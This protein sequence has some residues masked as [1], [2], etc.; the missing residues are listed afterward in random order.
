MPTKEISTKEPHSKE[1][2]KPEVQAPAPQPTTRRR[3][4]KGVSPARPKKKVRLG[5]NLGIASGP[6]PGSF[7]NFIYHGGRVIHNPQVYCVFLGDWSSASNQNR[8]TRLAQFIND[9]LNSDYM[10]MLTQYGVG[11]SGQVVN[12]VFIANS[13]QNLAQADIENILQTAINNNT[14]PDPGSNTSSNVYV[15]VLD[16][17]TAVNGSFGGEPVVMC[18]AT[19]DNAFG[20]HFHMNTTAAN[21]LFYAVVPGLTDTC[22]QNSCSNDGLCSL[23]LGQARE[24]RQ[25]QVISHEVS[26]MI[27]N[28]DV[29]G[30]EGWS[31]DAFGDPHENG[32]ICNGQSGTLT[33]GPDTWNV[34]LMYSK[35]DD[36]QTNGATTCVL[37]SSFPL[38]SLLPAC[39]ILLDR[40][41]FGKDEVDAFLNAPVNPG[42]AVFDAAF[43]V[44]VDGFTA[45]QLGITAASFVG[46]PNVQPTFGTTPSV[47]GM[48]ITATSLSAPDQSVFDIIQRFT[49]VCQVTFNND[50]AFP[51]TPGGV[52]TV[53]LS[54]SISG[55]SGQADIQLVNE[56]NPY[57][58]DG[59]I[60][61]LSTD[62]RVFQIPQGNS[63]FGETMGSDASAFITNIITRL[64]TGNTAGQS[65]DDI[66]TDETASAL[67]LSQTVNGTPIYN[68][69]LARVRY[70]ALVADA[71]DV[72]VFF[73][74][75]PGAT[76]ST[77]YDTS[78]TYRRGG[79][80]G[81]IIPLLGFVGGQ[82]TTIPCFASSRI[83]TTSLSMNAQ[84]DEPNHQQINHD[85]S[86]AEVDVYFGCWLDINQPTPAL[87]PTSAPISP[88]PLDGPYS[89]PL[90]SVQN[91][92][93]N[94]HQCLTAEISMDGVTL[95]TAGQ[96]PGSSDKLAQRNL[97][98]VASDNP[99]SPASHR[100]PMTFEV[101]PTR[102]ETKV[103]SKPDELLINWGDTP[104]GSVASLY[105]PGTSAQHIVQL[106][107]SLY[108][109]HN[110]K[111][112]DAH[113]IQ[114][115]TGGITY[116]P[117]P[118]S[119]GADYAGLLTVDL[120][121]TVKK[122]QVFKVVAQQ[123][124][125][126]A[127]FAV[128]PPPPNQPGAP[129]NAAVNRPVIHWRKVTGSFQL[130]IPVKTKEVMLRPEERLLGVLKWIQKSVP[131]GDRWKPVF[132][133]YVGVIADRVEALGG[134]PAKIKPSPG[135][136]EHGHP[137]HEGGHG[138][139]SGVCTV[140]KVRE[141]I[142]DRYGEFEGFVLETEEADRL[143]YAHE[144]AL[145][146]LLNRSWEERIL[147][148]VVTEEDEPH[149]PAS[150]GLLRK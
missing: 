126:A 26:E 65:F 2:R 106:A 140:G 66:S 127:G 4:I 14:I 89:G 100:V 149:R 88:A 7:P 32:D 138:R 101:K 95:I 123:L 36:Q 47:S 94:I 57:E 28:P 56:P 29:G 108:V 121:K 132:D 72:R 38:P 91:L 93:R 70:R 118:P 10:N 90:Q 20:F 119:V 86:G 1:V 41:T 33:V 3:A 49:W 145:A 115:P 117:I 48:S 128:Q 27:T 64:N 104:E 103:G 150:I 5:G 144:P 122:G 113:T 110:L 6:G 69:G 75:F 102:I 147:I 148:K 131:E 76:T 114:T 74:L 141:L 42:P 46:T 30:S 37:G 68:F 73:R 136:Q 34:Q 9:M 21:E 135:D 146:H 61:W 59:P 35:Y 82:T 87:F 52:D 58:I 25:T 63:I 16:D 107:N 105:L 19:S 17:S 134:D 12:S 92:I 112:V 116:V 80:G 51:T 120:P 50:S 23:H 22:L 18:E 130:T 40:S 81:T 53:T 8:A 67:E 13:N 55:V 54:A 96:T 60:S 124:T 98:I 109:R 44:A 84:T 139:E 79:Q 137:K 78:T 77:A 39:T 85:G 111:A 142:Y 99:G 71:H 97:T 125:D 11:T 83:D 143:Y 15:L 45:T 43:Y 24:A 133:R 62:L 129:V 31:S